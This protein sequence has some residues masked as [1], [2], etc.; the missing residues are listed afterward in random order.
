MSPEKSSADDL[1]EPEGVNAGPPVS[2]DG[3]P[4]PAAPRGGAHDPEPPAGEPGTDPP[5]AAGN[6][7]LLSGG[8]A[9]RTTRP[10]QPGQ[11]LEAGE[12]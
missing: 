2:G 10:P 12:A 6:G 7:E 3:R 1:V 4:A 9:T 11:E 8:G 5:A